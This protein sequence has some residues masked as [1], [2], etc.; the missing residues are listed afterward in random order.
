MDRPEACFVREH[1]ML[2][3]LDIANLSDKEVRSEETMAIE[4]QLPKLHY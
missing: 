3:E 2:V 1:E 4:R